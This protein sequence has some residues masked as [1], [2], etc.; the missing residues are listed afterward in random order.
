MNDMRIVGLERV[1]RSDVFYRR[2]REMRWIHLL[3]TDGEHGGCNK[4][5]E[6]VAV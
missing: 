3:G 2:Q 1:W 5:K 4:R 6:G